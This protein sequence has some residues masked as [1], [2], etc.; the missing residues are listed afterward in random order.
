MVNSFR[1]MQRFFLNFEL[2]A[3]FLDYEYLVNSLI[4]S[5]TEFREGNVEL[6][7]LSEFKISAPGNTRE[8]SSS[9]PREKRLI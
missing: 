9:G 4:D 1:F 2:R 5:L 3:S 7:C 8:V 6:I